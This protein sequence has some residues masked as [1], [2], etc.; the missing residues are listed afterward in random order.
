MD[1]VRSRL[2]SAQWLLRRELPESEFAL[3]NSDELELLRSIS[4]AIQA[5]E[6]LV[7]D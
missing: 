7:N 2:V 5:L 4:L 6:R 3:L 1:H